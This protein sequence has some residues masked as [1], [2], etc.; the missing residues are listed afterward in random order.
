M[1][2]RI[3]EFN[4]EYF[5]YN[6]RTDELIGSSKSKFLIGLAIIL[7]CWEVEKEKDKDNEEI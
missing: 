1:K 2:V 6:S 7:N 4:S 3:N 5:V